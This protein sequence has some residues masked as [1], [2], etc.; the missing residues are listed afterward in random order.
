MTAPANINAV[1]A[2]LL[3]KTMVRSDCRRIVL[4]PGSRNSPLTVAAARTPEL[5]RTIHFDERAAA[6][7][8]LGLARALDK[9]VALAC[10]S[11][12]AVA[13]Y[14][15]AVVEA[16]MDGVPLLLLTADRPPELHACGA[17]QTIPQAGLFGRFV[18]HELHLSCPDRSIPV[19]AVARQ[20]DTALSHLAGPSR[21]PVHVNCPFREP[22]APDHDGQDYSAHARDIESHVALAPRPQPESVFIPSD[23]RVLFASARRGVIV[24]GKLEYASE[25]QAV[26][27]LAANCGWPIL[28]DIQSGLRIGGQHRNVISH[29][30]QILL[31]KAIGAQLVPDFILHVGGRILSRRLLEWL[32]A[33]PKMT[34]YLRL[35]SSSLPFDPNHQATLTLLADPAIACE[36]LSDGE[37]ATDPSWL[38]RWRALDCRVADTI[39]HHPA[40]AGTAA[41][42]VNIAVALTRHLTALPDPPT[43]WAA[44]SLPIRLVDMY[45]PGTGANVEALANRGA[46]G[47]DGTIASAAG[48]AEG[49][50]RP[51]V[52]L[53]GDLAFLHDLT[54]LYLVRRL[55][56]PMTIV[57]L[58]NNGGNIFGLLPIANHVDVYEKYFLTSHNLTFQSAAAQFGLPYVRCESLGAF[59]AFLSDGLVRSNSTLVE[60][61]IRPGAGTSAMKA[62]ASAVREALDRG[63]PE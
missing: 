47:I 45:A 53:I 57:L 36:Q 60:V 23:L 48:Y 15:P 41:T 18:R 40:A 19:E 33:K 39:D 22:L 29:I 7:Y 37:T 13:N 11:G 34:T 5:T 16:A 6:F 17:N 8:A 55:N 63:D 10:T 62:L 32:D 24:A 43:L 30:D 14:L 28:P 12:S 20:L 38:T 54:S 51:T 46:S 58:N 21:G 42:D 52:L 44:S 56:P 59:E 4:S 35:S 49:S 25:R 31:S 1:W 3:M 27:Q 61:V 26:L 50:G 2:S 9:P